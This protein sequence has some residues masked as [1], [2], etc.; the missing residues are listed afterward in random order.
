MKIDLTVTVYQKMPLPVT[1]ARATAFRRLLTPCGDDMLINSVSYLN[2]SPA[3]FTDI[4]M[5]KLSH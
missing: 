3:R 2:T 1:S 4:C 5:L